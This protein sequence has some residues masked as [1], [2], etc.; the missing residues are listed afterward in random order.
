MGDE[1]LRRTYAE[2]LGSEHGGEQPSFQ[3]ALFAAAD[4]STTQVFVTGDFNIS[5]PATGDVYSIR[6]PS[7]FV[8]APV[9]VV[10]RSF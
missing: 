1:R 10:C 2:V 8:Y 6:K 9:A 5:F 4:P 3:D 7:S